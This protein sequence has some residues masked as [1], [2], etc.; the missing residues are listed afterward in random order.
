MLDFGG[1]TFDVSVIETTKGGDISQSGK[2]SRPLA[3]K[4][5][6]VGGFFI[7][8]KIAERL[9]FS[10]L[11]DKNSKTTARKAL[12][13]IG[14]TGSLSSIDSE[15]FPREQANFIGHFQSLLEEVE[16]AKINICGSIR[17]W[18]LTDNVSHPVRQ[19][20]NVPRSPFSAN[21]EFV[22]ISLSA[23]EV[24][25]VFLNDVWNGRLKDAITRAVKR[26]QE[27]IQGKPI[28]VV[29]LSGGSTNI[30]WTKTLIER[31]LSALLDDAPIL[32]IS[33]NYQ[34]VVA[35]GLAVECARQFYTEGDGDFG[36]VTYNRLNLV[37]RSDEGS[38]RVYPYKPR[39]EGLPQPEGDGILLPSAASLRAYQGETISWKVR[40]S[41]APSHSLGYYYLKSSFDPDDVENLHNVGGSRIFI[42]NK[43]FGQAIDV[44]L[45]VAADG[46][47]HPSFLINRGKEGREERI[48]GDSFYLDMTYAG[49]HISQES[50]LGLD[51]GT[52]TSAASVVFQNDIKAYKDRSK[53]RS[54]LELS[55]LIERLPY[56]IAHPLAQY[57][58]QTDRA[59]LEA[60][61]KSAIEAMLT[62]SAYLS[63]ADV[64]TTLGR[65]PFEFPEN[66]NRSAG[67]L[68]DLMSRLSGFDLSI[69]KYAKHLMFLS[70]AGGQICSREILSAI[71]DIKHDRAPSIDF[72]HTLAQLGNVVLR[73]IGK[74]QLGSFEALQ[75][76]A[77]GSGYNGIFRCYTGSNPPFIELHDY[78]GEMDFRMVDVFLADFELG[79][80]L[81]LSP[82]YYSFSPTDF[83]LKGDCPL[84]FLDSIKGSFED[85]RYV[86]V[87]RGEG[88][89]VKGHH[90]LDG[91]GQIAY[92][93]LKGGD[94]ARIV[95]GLKFFERKQ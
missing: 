34:E 57:V 17:N 19:I 93:H 68:L 79:S 49:A 63:F 46:S 70:D 73:A 18:D 65:K 35:K 33:E 47:A 3:A 60:T 38:P 37:L 71:N 76:Q 41:S 12:K 14:D 39:S 32:E 28:S 84:H 89:N 94:H 24:R 23:S 81:A 95:E 31:D 90:V 27:E 7:N 61:W 80:A 87:K 15:E 22:G 91:V 82:L 43:V 42:K 52:A 44:E 88:V 48:A 66:F 5:I 62:F 36:A 26:A 16:A 85:Y 59:L 72:N 10:T 56:P 78:S 50:Y 74:R 25:D 51:F 75:R 54:W 64:S 13:A 1:G 58:S 53:D 30:G 20:V 9:L 86:P 4:S 21:G 69:S 6:S 45:K 29:L 77:F 83:D 55:D 11:P 2:A 67:P 92:E 40:L 8:Q